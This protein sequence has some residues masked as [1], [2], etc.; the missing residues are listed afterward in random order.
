V[1]DLSLNV[2]KYLTGIGLIPAPVQVLGRNAK[3]NDQI[4]GEIL[5][6]HFAPLF[7]P[8][9]EERGF[10]VPDNDP[11][12]RPADEVASIRKFADLEV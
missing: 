5:R 10:I 2:R 8:E 7:S 6:L 4:A 9:A 11:G 1:P 12:V 3:L